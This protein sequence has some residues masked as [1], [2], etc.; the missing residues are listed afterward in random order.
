MR[1]Y[2]P[3]VSRQHGK[4]PRVAWTAF[5]SI[6][7]APPNM[8]RVRS[9]RALHAERT[10]SQGASPQGIFTNAPRASWRPNSTQHSSGNCAI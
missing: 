7:L 9:T 4:A 10:P 1:R 3:L 8:P 6:Q 2:A 5:H